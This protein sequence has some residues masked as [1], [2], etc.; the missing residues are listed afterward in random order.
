MN[1]FEGSRRIAKLIGACIAVG[2]IVGGL[3]LSPT[4]DVNYKI[5]SVGS[6]PIQSLEEC[7]EDSRTKTKRTYTRKHTILNITLCFLADTN[8]DN[9]RVIPF[10][11]VL[12]EGWWGGK[13]YS[14]EVEEY[15]SKVSDSFS[16]PIS[17]EAALDAQYWKVLLKD[18][19]VG[20]MV[21]LASLVSFWG[22]TWAVGWIVRGFLGIPR[23][24]DQKAPS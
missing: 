13:K 19:A 12:G 22:F 20:S 6:T 10:K 7:P 3:H 15:T 24:M 17:D 8:V 1:I 23:G 18:L 14:F 9:Q 5:Q 21:A 11:E 4:V 2:F 16:I